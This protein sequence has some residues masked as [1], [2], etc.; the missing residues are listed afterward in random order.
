MKNLMIVANTAFVCFCV[1]LYISYDP[2]TSAIE[3]AVL[4]AVI[5]Q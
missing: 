4:T 3:H 2:T 5:G 1:Y